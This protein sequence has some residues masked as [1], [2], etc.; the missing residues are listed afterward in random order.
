[1]KIFVYEYV[2][3]TMNQR[4][5]AMPPRV[6]SLMAEGRTML[7]AAMEDC[8]AI[9]GTEVRTIDNRAGHANEESAFRQL[10]DWCDF[11]LIIAPEFDRILKTRCRWAIECRATLLGPPPEVVAL[12]A[13][14]LALADVWEKADVPSPPTKLFDPWAFPPP[15][16]VKPRDGV[17]AGDTYCFKDEATLHNYRP[18]RPSIIQPYTGKASSYSVAFM[19]GP[20]HAIP[21]APCSQ[22]IAIDGQSGALTYRG[23]RTLSPTG[24]VWQRVVEKIQTLA[25]AAVAAVPGLIGY[26][27]V[28]LQINP[29]TVFEINPRLTTSYIGLRQLAQCNLMEL[30]I[31]V[32]NG[33][34]CRSPSWHANDVQF[35]PDGTNKKLN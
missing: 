24:P 10:A 33:E 17:G 34:P 5:E 14:K 35:T 12:C 20:D 15:V 16:V 9:A 2:C 32:V 13:D 1:M 8:N 6:A 3:A 22:D 26:V 23:G 30:L 7:T 21:L 27:G 11:A 31:R 18:T 29:D 19:I 28:D 25:A 4:P